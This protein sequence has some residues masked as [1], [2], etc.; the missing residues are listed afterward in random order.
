MQSRYRKDLKNHEMLKLT[1]EKIDTD[2][3][4]YKDLSY[5]VVVDNY[6]KK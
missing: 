3:M 2:I 5:L 4:E 6:S 1:F